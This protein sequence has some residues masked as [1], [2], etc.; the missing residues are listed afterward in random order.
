LRELRFNGITVQQRN[1]VGNMI[2]KLKAL[3]LVGCMALAPAAFA[4]PFSI[5][6]NSGLA[7]GSGNWGLSGATTTG[8]SF[9]LGALDSETDTANINA[10]LHSWF[11]SGSGSA[12]FSGISWV[13]RVNGDVV[14]S[15][16]DGAALGHFRIDDSGRFTAVPEP[17]T[18]ALLGLGL[19]GIGF[20]VR[21]R[22]TEV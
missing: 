11:V 20:S 22:Q 10:G 13:L 8:G 21:R 1:L 17:G 18:L 7:S 3:V 15:G 19:L 6:F 5:T 9:N 14:G 2:N 12:F 16:S 4:I